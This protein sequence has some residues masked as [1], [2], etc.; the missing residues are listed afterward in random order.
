M[1]F[2]LVFSTFFFVTVFATIPLKLD[3]S[4][5]GDPCKGSD[6]HCF[7]R[8]FTLLLPL[9]IQHL[10]IPLTIP[11]LKLGYGKGV[12][13]LDQTY[14]HM[15]IDGLNKADVIDS[16]LDLAV[17]KLALFLKA[18]EIKIQTKYNIN[19]RCLALPIWG[20]GDATIIIKN[21]EIH[22]DLAIGLDNGKIN[23]HTCKLP[24]KAGG[25]HFKFSS[26][27]GEARKKI[28]TPQFEKVFND[29][30]PLVLYELLPEFQIQLEKH[31]NV[32][33]K[34]LLADLPLD[35]ILLIPVLA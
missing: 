17:G 29:N 18:K 30:A 32:L 28:L 31:F 24:I 20:K 7:K 23:L 3:L 14:E 13:Q 19:G 21:V 25:A 16:K 22:L 35:A 12:L 15:K 8:K 11:K 5:L 34:P 26:L 10:G 4:R 6:E 9:L 27:F 1:K 2:L 33:L